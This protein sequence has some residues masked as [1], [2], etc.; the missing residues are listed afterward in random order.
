MIDK[1][2][3]VIRVAAFSVVEALIALTATIYFEVE[4]LL[5]PLLVL[6]GVWG[7]YVYRMNIRVLS[8]PVQSVGIEGSEG[9]ALTDINGEGKIKVGGEI[10]NARSSRKIK[11]GEKVRVLTREGIVLEVGPVE[12]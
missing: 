9:R 2:E 7:I 8:M 5:I 3:I 1:K 6:I 12:D 4:W 11:K 10:W